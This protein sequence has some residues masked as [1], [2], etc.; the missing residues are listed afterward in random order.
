MDLDNSFY[1]KKT[2]ILYINLNYLLTRSFRAYSLYITDNN[3]SKISRKDKNKLGIHFIIKEIM[4]AC[5]ASRVKK[6]F[7]YTESKS[8]ENTLVKKISAA[9][10]IAII[11]STLTFT[12]F[13]SELNC[14]AYND[15]DLS[16]IDFA[17]FRRFL[18]RYDL[19]QIESQFLTNINV[20]FSLLP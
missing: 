19:Q 9:L 4:D 16:K 13:I 7:L 20:K 12:D 3:L 6:R 8:I 15:A 10:P 5:V 11:R 18:K 14:F 1:D 17:K 2:N